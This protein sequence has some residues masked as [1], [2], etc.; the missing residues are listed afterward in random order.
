MIPDYSSRTLDDLTSLVGKRAVVT[1]GAQGIGAATVARLAEAGADVLVTDIDEVGAAAMAATVA[2]Q[3]GRKV[4]ST[5]IDI[6]DT[7][8]IVAA[9]DLCVEKLGG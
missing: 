9:A 3:T 2:Q 4:I 5:R 6:G 8:T 7:S 1:G